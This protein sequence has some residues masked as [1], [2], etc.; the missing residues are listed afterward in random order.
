MLVL[1]LCVGCPNK[2]PKPDGKNKVEP[3]VTPEPA[4]HIEPLVPKVDDPPTET[5]PPTKTES[6]APETT[7]ITSEALGKY[8]AE[9]TPL[10]PLEDLT[11]QIDEYIT[12]IEKALDDLDGSPKYADD[13]A[14]I[15]RDTTAVTLI[16]LAIGLADVDSK[17][18][19]SASQIITAAQTLAAAKNLDEGKK[20]YDA[21]KASLTGTGSGKTLVWTD[22]IVRLTPAMKALPNLH[23][24]VKRTTDTEGKLMRV[25]D[26]RAQPVYSQ[27][28]ALAVISQGCIPNVTD[29]P[30][31]DAAAEWKKY[32]EEFRDAALKA[33]VAA[34]QYAGDKAD[35][36]EPNY[37]AF[38]ASFKAMT[39]SCDSC[40]KVFYP[41]AVGKSE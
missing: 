20:G 15:V 39:E 22:K 12:K 11:A 35:G 13:A 18:K 10:P 30:K 29:T 9:A 40:H 16:A 23:A 8:A 5:D 41:H 7:G 1:V 14:N 17:Y 6:P 4:G 27:L 24:A 36:K 38:D 33:N 19:K 32:C 34:H 26:R 25:L 3:V 28:A 21:L 31:P 2:T 37:A